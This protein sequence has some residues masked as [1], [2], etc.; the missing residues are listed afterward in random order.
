MAKSRLIVPSLL[1]SAAVMLAACGNSPSNGNQGGKDG[2]G[3]GGSSTPAGTGGIAGGNGTRDAGYTDVAVGSDTGT[4]RDASSLD[5]L[6]GGE[7]GGG[8]ELPQQCLTSFVN[9]FAAL[10]PYWAN[11]SNS[12][13]GSAVA[14]NG[15]LVLTQNEPCGTASPDVIEGLTQPYVL[16][17]DFDVQVGYALTGFGAAPVGGMFASL[18]VDDPAAPLTGMT[19]ERYVA[20]YLPSSNSYQNYKSYTDNSGNDATSVLLATSDTTGRLR[21][22]RSGTTVTS[23]YWKV[24]TT[25]AGTGQWVLVKTAVLTS[26]PW[27]VLLYEGDNSAASSVPA[28]YSVTFSNLQV[29]SPGPTDAGTGNGPL[30]DAGASDAPDAAVAAD[31][32][33]G[34]Q[35]DVSYLGDRGG[36][37][38]T[39]GGIDAGKSDP[40]FSNVVLL[41][42]FDGANG[43]TSFTDVKGHAVTPH[44]SAAL[45]GTTSAF[46]GASGH[47]DGSSAWLSLAY[48]DDWNFYAADFTVELFVNFTGGVAGQ[49]LNPVFFQF[50]D[51]PNSHGWWQLAYDRANPGNDQI[52]GTL[53]FLFSLTGSDEVPP[54]TTWTPAADTWYHVASVR[55]G[56]DFLFFVNGALIGSQSLGANGGPVD[57]TQESSGTWVAGNVVAGDASI[58][59]KSTTDFATPLSIGVSIGTDSVANPWSYF[60]GNIDEVRITKGVARYTASF[61]AP[62]GPFPDN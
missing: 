59:S 50:W 15:N 58:Q 24:G 8:G 41:M 55:H 9:P 39:S 30:A 11:W 61:T 13:C 25:D 4:V 40:Y 37:G 1:F 17:G 44:G 49:T 26:T 7:G 57:W 62:T 2:G 60:N 16:C 53:E 54:A 6:D 51:G 27:V 52:P 32:A 28:S 35:P 38:D 12:T 45:S 10:T 46:G 20:S 36:D 21:I 22:T 43:A 48:S 18:R 34:S 29:T 42:H 33:D 47:F 19:M 31:A 23:Y 56:S 14:S 5:S 3:H